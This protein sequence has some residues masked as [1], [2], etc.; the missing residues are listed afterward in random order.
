M[1]L[2]TEQQ[3]KVNEL[4]AV[5]LPKLPKGKQEFAAS[6]TG[7]ATKKGR[8]SEKQWEWVDRLIDLAANPPAPPKAIDLGSS[9]A[10]VIA[11]FD[12]AASHLKRPK[13]RL[14]VADT[15]VRLMRFGSESMFPGAVGVR[16]GGS[17]PSYPRFYVG[18]IEQDGRFLPK[19]EAEEFPFLEDLLTAIAADPAKVMADYG[20]LAGAC[21]MCGKGLDVEQSTHVGYG[22]VCAKKWGLPYPTKTELKKEKEAA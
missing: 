2:T 5:A 17:D 12:K 1:P 7:Q 9:V 13:I 18:R 10:G 8:L 21:C 14:S 20:K 19:R 4:A 3:L 15:P 16:A 11:L 22:P 6:L